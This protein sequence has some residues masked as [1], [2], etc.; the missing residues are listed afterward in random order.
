VQALPL[1][2]L[3]V[4]VVSVPAIPGETVQKLLEQ[5]TLARIATF[6]QKLDGVLGVAAIDLTTG[7]EIHY[8]A[9]TIFPQASSIKIPIMLQ[10]FK[11]AKAGDLDLDEVVNLTPNDFVGGSGVLQN[12]LKQGAIKVPIR[13]IVTAMI[14][15]SDNSATN[16]CIRK[17]GMASVNRT[18]DEL[19]F[20]QTRLRRIML[21]QPA[22]SRDEENVSTPREMARLVAM[23]YQHKLADTA[24]TM[25][26]LAMMKLVKADFR[27]AIPA[28][29]EVAA[30]PGELNGV[31]CETGVVF[32]KGRPF[33]LSVMTTYLGK[34]ESQVG[35]VA[36]ILFEHYERLARGN[37]YGNLGVR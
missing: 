10:M 16:W 31:R 3:L 23:L 24:S 25:D 6:D 1:T 7:E 32:L 11:A 4:C 14:E 15:E 37:R 5:K 27:E 34:E 17:V 28:E 26:M 30:K 21:D 33:A 12:R 19:S 36:R 9:D 8:H 22:A 13:Q 29:V 2:V 20:V 35:A 18:L